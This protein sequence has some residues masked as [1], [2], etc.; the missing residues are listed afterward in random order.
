MARSGFKELLLRMVQWSEA[1]RLFFLLNARETAGLLSPSALETSIIGPLTHGASKVLIESMAVPAASADSFVPWCLGVA[2]GNPFFLQELTHHWIETG[3]RHEVPPSVHNILDDR[4]AYLSSDALQV[5]QTSSL[6]SDHASVVR[7]ERVLEFQPHRFLAALEELS[8]AAMLRSFVAG[9]HASGGQIQPRHDLLS[10]AAIARLSPIPLAFLHRRSAEIIEAEFSQEI[11]PTALLWAC[12]N[13]RHCAGDRERA[14]SLSV[15]CAEHLLDLGLSGDAAGGFQQ[16]LDYCH[17]E[18]ERL[19]VLPRYAFALQLAGKWEEGKSVLRKCIAL[20]QMLYPNSTR[21][22][23]FELLLLEATH[24]SSFDYL[25]L[26]AD[27]FA[28]VESHE[29]SPAHR[30]RAAVLALKLATDFGPSAL[31]DTLYGHVSPFMEMQEIRES[32]RLEVQIVYNTL[33]AKDLIPLEELDRFAELARK[34]EGELGYFNALMTAASACR[35]SGRFEAGLN[36]VDR[37]F[38][39]AQRQ[40]FFDRL[41]HALL[42][43]VRL[44]IAA[45]DFVAADQALTRAGKHFTTRET[46]WQIETLFLDARIALAKE[47]L[48]RARASFDAIGQ[49]LPT[50]SPSRRAYYLALETQVRVREEAPREVLISV[51]EALEQIHPSIQGIGAKDFETY[52]LY[53][54]LCA[55]GEKP[56][57]LDMLRSYVG[58]NRRSKW[59]LPA[60]IVDTLESEFA[61]TARESTQPPSGAREEVIT[62]HQHSAW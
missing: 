47:D 28:C 17:S 61:T 34:N 2:E 24:Q 32:D 46:V 50:Y 37:A 16:C 18:E 35:I 38:G 13:H 62:N 26:L 39:H 40:K 19:Q 8:K 14:L 25:P 33:R 49:V 55:I 45:G 53:L 23:D 3:H 15:A 44:Q 22:T 54:G 43:A 4:L 52:S 1:K 42:G 48:P 21:H 41:T 60:C 5:L 29:A 31:I 51:V 59:P 36:Y 27:T 11:M 58:D 9:A 30:M 10:S 6:L 20:Y 56:K 12:A 57:A 7:I